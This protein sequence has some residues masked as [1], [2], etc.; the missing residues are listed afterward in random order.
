MLTAE[1]AHGPASDHGQ[2]TAVHNATSSS[3][4]RSASAR[5]VSRGACA[6]ACHAQAGARAGHRESLP[7]ALLQQS[8]RRGPAGAAVLPVAARAAAGGLKQSD[9]FAPVRVADYLLEKDRL[10]ARITLDDA[11]YG[12]YEQVYAKLDIQAPEAGPGG[13]PAGAGGCAAGAHRA[14][15]RRLRAVHRPRSTWSGS[16]RPMRASSTSSRPRRC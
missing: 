4:A 12:L 15:R 1:W 7:R 6:R 5:P 3:K 11:E 10:F 14:A 2:R 16:T 8:A 13:V 9:L